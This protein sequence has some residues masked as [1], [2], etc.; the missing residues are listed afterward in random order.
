M[1][2]GG[3]KQPTETTQHV[4]QSSLPEY[5]KPYYEDLMKRAQQETAQ[6]YQAY[7]GPRVAGFNSDQQAGFQAA[8]DYAGAGTPEALTNAS[9]GITTAMGNVAGMSDF[10]YTPGQINGTY[11]PTDFSLQ[12]FDMNSINDY[13]NPYIGNV[14]DVAR[15]DAM[16]T[17]G[18]QR[19][20][21]E[22]RAGQ[23]GAFGGYRHAIQE[24]ELDRA[25]QDTIARYEAQLLKEGYT[26]AANRAVDMFKFGAG[27]DLEKQRLGEQSKQYG[28]TYQQTADTANQQ[29]QLQA[30]LDSAK[31]RLQSASTSIDAANAQAQIAAIEDEIRRNQANALLTTGAQQQAMQQKQYDT[32]Y[33]D[34]TNQRDYERQ[35]LQFLSG[36]LNGVPV[37]ANSN[38]MTY[39]APPNQMSQML[40]MGLGAAG[41]WG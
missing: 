37:S 33:E 38:V 9:G 8:R 35:N 16:R 7:Q 11:A 29:N 34:F 14:L 20:G 41:L 19:Q 27:Q 23:A 36:I 4:Y 2:K 25:T 30:A 22:S 31:I 6:P 40:G 10:S 15:R 1:A 21:I 3:G 28:A 13:M 39:Q 24:S 26:D 12:S 17:A 5:A 18:I 32:A